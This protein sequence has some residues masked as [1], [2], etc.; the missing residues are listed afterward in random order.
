M[1]ETKMSKWL[2]RIVIICAIAGFILCLISA[3]QTNQLAKRVF[4]IIGLTSFALTFLIAIVA[5]VINSA[6]IIKGVKDEAKKQR[7]SFEEDK[8]AWEKESKAYINKTA[9]GEEH[10]KI[11]AVREIFQL[12]DAK[13]VAK[14]TPKSTKIMGGIFVT[15]II[16][17]MLCLVPLLA[18]GHT[19]A[20]L[21]VFGSFFAIMIIAAITNAVIEKTSI[22]R[23][24][25]YVKDKSEMKLTDGEEKDAVVLAS[26]ISSESS[27][28]TGKGYYRETTK[29][30]ST[31]YRIIVDVDGVQKT[32]YSKTPYNE[33]DKVKVVTKQNAKW[34]SIIE[35]I[36]EPA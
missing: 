16:L 1:K 12:A 29:L 24:N 9:Y 25:R 3:Y 27:L 7:E 28:S 19:V 20:G 6:H 23:A 4:M 34:A 31:T 11:M 15:V 22:S 26:C 17:L 5:G 36:Q 35:K 10:K 30:L 13:K 8:S 33:G 2:G 18:T 32:A 14:Y 21:I